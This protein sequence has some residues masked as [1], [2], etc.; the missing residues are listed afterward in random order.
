MYTKDIENIDKQIEELYAK[1]AE[2]E[3]KAEAK[4]K[5]E[6]QKKEETRKQDLESIKNAIKEY[7]EKY[8]TSLILGEEKKYDNKSI[9]SLFPWW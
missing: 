6:E 7:N 9:Y 1:K 3:T 5:E 4:R 2:L 8:N